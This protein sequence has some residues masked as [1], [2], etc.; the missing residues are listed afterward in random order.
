[1]KRLGIMQGRL[2]TIKKGKIQKFPT[3]NWKD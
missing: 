3:D 2:N 1:M